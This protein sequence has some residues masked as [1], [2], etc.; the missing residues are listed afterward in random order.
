MDK[1]FILTEKNLRLFGESVADENNNYGA[2]M[3]L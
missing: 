1:N 3:E 2:L